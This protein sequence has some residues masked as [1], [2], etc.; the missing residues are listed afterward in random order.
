MESTPAPKC[1]RMLLSLPTLPPPP[2]PS[3]GRL[4]AHLGP[5]ARDGDV[6]PDIRGFPAA[7]GP[8]DAP[9][10]LSGSRGPSQAEAPLTVVLHVPGPCLCA[11][12]RGAWPT[13]P[14][15]NLSPPQ[16]L[17]PLVPPAALRRTSR[18]PSGHYTPR[19]SVRF[20]G[21]CCRAGCL[22]PSRR[23]TARAGLRARSF[24]P[25]THPT[26]GD[27][28]NRRAEGAPAPL[29]TPGPAAFSSGPLDAADPVP[30]PP[31]RSGLHL[32]LLQFSFG[33]STLP[34]TPARSV[35]SP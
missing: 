27:S 5:A 13:L 11:P 28:S 31:P 16:A 22:P 9:A 7:R 6:M 8:A 23:S 17:V 3:P 19:V 35:R 20:P 30:A 29:Q 2:R 14:A 1:S 34:G 25:R 10:L 32:R 24:S 21:G 12:P 33:R 18:A 26:L 4:R 15:V